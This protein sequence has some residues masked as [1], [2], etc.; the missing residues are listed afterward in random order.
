MPHG[1]L[2]VSSAAYEVHFGSGN[3]ASLAYEVHLGSPASKSQLFS[4]RVVYDAYTLVRISIT[5]T[6]V[7]P[8]K[9]ALPSII[10]SKCSHS[11][12]A[13]TRSDTYPLL[14]IVYCWH[15]C[16]FKGNRWASL[17]DD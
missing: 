15:R 13:S 16:P 1:Q 4:K 12:D 10:T 5:V 2:L 6:G 8:T 9:R 17:V 3:W 7:A 14:P 11:R